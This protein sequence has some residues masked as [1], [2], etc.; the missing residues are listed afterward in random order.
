MVLHVSWKANGSV[1]IRKEEILNNQKYVFFTYAKL[2]KDLNAR[3]EKS[4]RN[5]FD[6][7]EQFFTPENI[8]QIFNSIIRLYIEN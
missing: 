1:M 6:V 3:I 7:K 8:L 4:T 2:G 5:F